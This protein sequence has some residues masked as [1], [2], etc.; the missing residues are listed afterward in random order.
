ME[1]RLLAECFKLAWNKY[2]QTRRNLFH[3]P[4]ERKQDP[5]KGAQM[6][7]KGVIAGVSDFILINDGK[8]YALECKLPDCRQSDSQKEW[9]QAIQCPYYIFRS[10]EE[11][12][13]ILKSII[14]L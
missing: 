9:Q 4:N 14:S 7:A 8:A 11:F 6:K 3:V 10:V 13:T 5:I 12:E 2:P 1:D